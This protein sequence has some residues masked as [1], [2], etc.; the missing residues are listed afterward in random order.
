LVFWP[1]LSRAWRGVLFALAA[2]AVVAVGYSRVAL[3]V[4]YT[5]DV[6]A[7]WCVGVGWVL[8]VAVL[9]RVWPDRL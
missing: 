9:L 5:S 2:I 4:H 6:V 8:V 1:L 7:G 3:G